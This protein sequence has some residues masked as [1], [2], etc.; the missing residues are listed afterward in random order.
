MTLRPAR[1]AD[2]GFIRGLAQRPD[3]APFISDDD[4]AALAA[5][6]ANP[7][8]RLLIWEQ[9]GQAAGFALYC[10]IGDPS[11]RIELRRLALAQTG[12]GAGRQFLDDMIDFAFQQLQAKRLWLDASS[13]NPRA[14]RVY[15][16]A[17]FTLEGRLR[18]HWYRPVL[19]RAVDLM[20]FGMLRDEWLA[21]RG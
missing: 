1:F 16:R 9:D 2:F 4:E 20:L 19:A 6:L 13:E 11:G 14:Q 17:G 12:S 5:H 18:G 8:H 7:A 21:R 3:Y 15:E 10:E